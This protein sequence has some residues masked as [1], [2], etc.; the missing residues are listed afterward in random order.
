L[1]KRLGTPY[2]VHRP[3]TGQQFC[4]LTVELPLVSSLIHTNKCE[5]YCHWSTVLWSLFETANSGRCAQ[6][7]RVA[8]H[9]SG[10]VSCQSNWTPV[11]DWLFKRYFVIK[12]Q[13]SMINNVSP[14]YG[15]CV[16]YFPRTSFYLYLHLCCDGTVTVPSST[17]MACRG[18]HKTKFAFKR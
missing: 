4:Y 17:G 6:V 13:H 15:F 7:V 11:L 8:K 18:Y 16:N 9:T 12:N 5:C 10:G 3:A 2:S 1:K 14:Y